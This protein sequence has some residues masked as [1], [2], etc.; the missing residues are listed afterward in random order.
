MKRCILACIV[1]FSRLCV[2]VS[3]RNSGHPLDT[4][5]RG[6]SRQPAEF[7]NRDTVSHEKTMLITVAVSLRREQTRHRENH[8]TFPSFGSIKRSTGS[9]AGGRIIAGANWARSPSF[10]SKWLANLRKLTPI[11]VLRRELRVKRYK[12]SIAQ[13]IPQRTSSCVTNNRT[14]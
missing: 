12:H 10:T 5:V 8:E 4:L 6:D 11:A 13:F 3:P 2:A 1:S 9:R 14:D 7:P